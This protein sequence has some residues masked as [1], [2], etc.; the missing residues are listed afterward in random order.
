[1]TQKK[2]VTT[3][4]P[5]HALNHLKFVPHDGL[6]YK[7]NLRHHH[8][9]ESTLPSTTEKPDKDPQ[10]WLFDK[11]SNNMDYALMTKI[12]LKIIVFKKIIKFIAL[13]CLLFLIPAL[14]SKDGDDTDDDKMA[15]NLDPYAQIDYRT[16]EVYSFAINAIEGFSSDKVVWCIGE[17]DVYCRFQTM[18]DNIDQ[19]YTVDQIIKYWRPDDGLKTKSVRTKI[20]TEDS[21][22]DSDTEISDDDSLQL[23]TPYSFDMQNEIQTLEPEYS[24]EDD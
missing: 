12:L 17:H 22:S 1:M 16:K 2:E 20:P 24:Q 15:R 13:I 4:K 11:I 19:S 8:A 5:K 3:E 10:F 18:F 23:T 9:E 14:N 21:D 7:Y 6:G